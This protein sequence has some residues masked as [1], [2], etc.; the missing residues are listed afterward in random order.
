MNNVDWKLMHSFLQVAQNG[1]L[2]S[3]ARNLGVSQPT[4]TRNIQA[5]EKQTKLQLF[6]RTTQGVSLTEAGNRLVDAAQSMDDAADQF[7]RQVAGLSDELVGDVR[8]SVSEIVGIY[9]LPP[10][11]AAFRK[12]HPAVQVEI[13]IS[14]QSASL[15]KRDADIALRM[16]RPTQLDLVVKRLPDMELGFYATEEY[17]KENG[18]PKE[19][20][21]FK[22]HSIIGNDRDLEFI[23]V[24]NQM[25]YEFSQHDFSLRTDNLMS[26]I[27]LARAGAGIVGT[28]VS[29]VKHWPELIRILHD[30]KIPPLEFWIVC[31]Q[32]TQYNSR[33]R[34]L[35]KFLSQWFMDDVYGKA[36]V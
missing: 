29:L 31:H 6:Q 8:I 35:T 20:E 25:G 19:F 21:D 24:A 9:L 34:A 13:E 10:A 30:F 27:Q 12:L 5:L 33:I 28:H 1:S 26:Q 18:I 36:L 7:N 2:S 14:N 11:L 4:L 32:D 23:E 3:A 17:I 16:Y 22:Q 15:N